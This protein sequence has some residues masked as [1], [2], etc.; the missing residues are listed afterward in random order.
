MKA[1]LAAA[2]AASGLF[3]T[4]ANALALKTAVSVLG[5]D[6]NACAPATPCRTISYALT[7]T[8]PGGQIYVM[9]SGGYGAFTVTQAV[10]IVA[11]TGTLA[12][13]NAASGNGVTIN[14]G[15]TDLVILEGLFID[16]LGTGGN[17][18]QVNSVGS[19]SFSGRVTGFTG[20]G[21]NYV[22]NAG[23]ALAV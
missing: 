19:F 18:I 17:G 5:S 15:P 21:L 20:Y 6:S 10:T 14:A 16:G 7:Q 11:P 3:C 8:A 4:Q 1:Y 13:V 22:N 12:A 9:T 2:V 23:R